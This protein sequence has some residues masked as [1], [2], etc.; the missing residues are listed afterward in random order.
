MIHK[1]WKYNVGCEG[2]L[3]A[4]KMNY[5]FQYHPCL[6]FNLFPHL[7]QVMDAISRMVSFC[8]DKEVTLLLCL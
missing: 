4:S 5:S 6:T 2:S 7:W 3:L 8:A 1:G